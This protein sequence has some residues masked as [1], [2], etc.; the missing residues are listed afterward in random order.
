MPQLEKATL[1]KV[2]AD[3]NERTIGEPMPVQFNPSSLTL[4]I[5]NQVEGGRANARQRRQQ[6]GAS[7]NV[8]SMELVFDTADEGSSAAPVSV[9]HKT[10]LVEQFVLPTPG[11]T[12]PPPR[13]KFHWGELIVVGIVE[14]LDIEFDLFASNGTPLRASMQVSIKEQKPQYQFVS[15]LDNASN[16][17]LPAVQVRSAAPGA[18]DADEVPVGSGQRKIKTAPALEGESAAEFASRQGLDPKAWRSLAA[19]LGDSLELPAGLEIGFDETVTV[20]TGIGA[21]VGVNASAAL[22]LENA[23]GITSSA[24]SSDVSIN[25]SYEVGKALSSAG[26]VAAALDTVATNNAAASA[27]TA[28]AAFNMQSNISAATTAESRTPLVHR[29]RVHQQQRVSSSAAPPS[30]P[31]LRAISFGR[32]VPLQPQT[33][34]TEQNFV[35]LCST[36]E[37][38]RGVQP[39]YR[40]DPSVA[41]WEA[42]PPKDVG[43]ILADR[44]ETEKRTGVCHLLSCACRCRS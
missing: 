44:L 31:D 2:R 27:S 19:D 24:E 20:T 22:T 3:K 33:R 9:R 34:V 7:S 16:S 30:R 42:L 13:I 18:L 6:T 26:G 12:K 5:S 21:A 14:S 8:L 25:S 37:I 23:L 10:A 4:K 41:P 36:S 35:G 38:E 1:Q 17:A 40:Q 11:N 43:R 29:K 15:Q 32:G 39:P 28:L